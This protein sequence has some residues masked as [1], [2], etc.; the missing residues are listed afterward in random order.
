MSSTPTER[1]LKES[2]Q[3][4]FLQ[5]MRK[6]ML[7][8]LEPKIKEFERKMNEDMKQKLKEMKEKRE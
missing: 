5:N 6:A 1:K 3:E 7:R 4:H 2:S 8:D